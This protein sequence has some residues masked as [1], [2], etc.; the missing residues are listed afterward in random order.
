VTTAADTT[1]RSVEVVWR[2][3][4]PRLI[5]GLVRIVGDVALAEDLAQEALVAALDQWPGDGLPRNPGAWL[6]TVAKRRAVDHV[7]RRE[8]ADRANEILGRQT[9][10]VD[11]PDLLALSGAADHIGDD[12]LRLM[13]VCCDPALT[14]DAQVTLTLRLVGGLTT[15]EIA[16]A[17]MTSESAIQQRIVRAKR[18][19]TDA[20]AAM[21]EPD[22]AERD[23]RLAAVMAVIYLIFNEGYTATAGA[24]WT[25]PTLCEEA[26]RVGRMLAVLAPADA[27]VHGLAALME[28]QASRFA[29]RVGADGEPVLLLDQQRSRW[30]RRSIRRGLAALERAEALGRPPGPYL[31]QA[32]IA[33]CHARAL[34]AADTD[35][36]RIAA[37]YAALAAVM[38]TPVVELNR[39][40]A[41]GMAQGPAAGLEVVD[42]LAGVPTLRDSSLLPSVRG[43]LLERLGRHDE[44]RA[45]FRRAA[46]MTSNAAERRLLGRRA[47]QQRS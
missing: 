14:I 35:W 29:A 15:K 40:V 36:A 44:A 43:D 21:E 20:R 3:E 31:L 1:R 47:A 23:E 19:L 10:T 30:D 46:A 37:L 4:A 18:T 32:Q 26:L 22:A 39:A 9:A 28:I 2:L 5:A 38:P 11:E 25:R 8:R 12:M 33:A 17:Y 6:T 42:R 27:E 34:R 24:D 45:E 41:V 16:R 7:R 13:F